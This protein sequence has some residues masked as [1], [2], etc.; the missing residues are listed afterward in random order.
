M[1]VLP[2]EGSHVILYGSMGFPA[3]A[4]SL[5]GYLAR[6]DLAGAYP[7]V[8]VAPT[9]AGITSSVKD[10]AR[11]LARHGL[12]VLV[13]DPHRGDAPGR[14]ASGDEVAAAVAKLT[15]ERVLADLDATLGYLRRPGTEWA[16]PD[17]IGLLGIGEGGRWALL[18]AAGDERVRGV[19]LA[20]AP[21]DAATAG[22]RAPVLG[23]YGKADEAVRA[24]DVAAAHAA[25]PSSEW[26]LYDGAGS[27]FLDDASDSYDPA[28][29]KDAL[30]RLVAFFTT[31]LAAPGVTAPT[32]R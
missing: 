23:L 10:L 15:D 29:T 13:L 11:R 16:D 5:S 28:A 12:A 19:A 22:V 25:I 3:R 32:R 6:P 30:D 27:G 1:S 4:R 20:Y 26:V 2:G 17:R 31:R 21:L 24:D 18:A 7:A 14:R 8:A 9:A